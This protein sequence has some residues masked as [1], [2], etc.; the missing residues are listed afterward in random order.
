MRN[1][2]LLALCV[3][4][5]ATPL[6]TEAEEADPLVLGVFPL[7]GKPKDAVID[8]DTIRVKGLDASLRLLCIDTE[9]TFKKPKNKAASDRDFPAYAKAMRG[10]GERPKKYGTPLGELAKEW[11]A[12]FFKGV[13]EVRLERDEASRTRGFYERHLVYVFAKKDGKWVNY[14]LEAVR[15]GMAPY[16]TKYGR[17]VRFDAEFK[18][19]QEE[20]RIAHRGIW[21]DALK[22]YPDYDE[23]LAW[24]EERAQ[25]I[26]RFRAKAAKDPTL[27]D[28]MADDGLKRAGEQ[29]G[30][31]VTVFSSFGEGR[32][33][34]KP[35][36]LP[37]SHRNR[38][39]FIIVA[40]DDEELAKIEY[41]KWKG[42]L[43]YVKGKVSQYKGKPQMKAQDVERIWE[44]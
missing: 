33:D 42:K 29:L 9:E 10:E 41:E 23:R 31:T 27:I 12:R 11:A 8:G 13:K 25:T 35:Y 17:C 2:M 22:H 39:D 38:N 44:E 24:W 36:L 28:L 6:R 3:L 26:D 5:L 40:F 32:L 4:F 21:S 18:A 1:P 20:A 37:L 19:A 7:K 15:A 43:I 30:K 16:F 14:N 34:K